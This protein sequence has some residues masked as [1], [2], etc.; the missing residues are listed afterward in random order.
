MKLSRSMLLAVLIPLAACDQLTGLVTDPDAPANLSYQLIPSGDPNAPL[1]VLLTWDVPS[2]GRGNAFNVYGRVNGADW[3]LRATTTSPTFHDAGIPETQYYVST[4]D[5]QGNELARSNTITIDMQARLPAP[6]GLRSISLNGAVQLQW[7]SNAVDASR[8]TFDH[9][10][11]YSATYDGTRGVCT[12]DWT[13]EGSTVSDAFLAANLTNGASRCFTVSAITHDGHES[14]WSDARVDTPRYDARN[15]IVYARPVKPDSAGFLFL[16]E[17]AKKIGVV[18][19][20]T[21]ADVDVTVERNAD[22]SL[23]LAPGRAGSTMTLY[24]TTAVPD[25]TSIDHAPASGFAS[26]AAIASPGFGYVFRLQK[27]DGVHFAAARVAYVAANYVVFD[28]S[29]QSAP[30]NAELNRAP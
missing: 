13:L 30:G 5:D 28:W 6:Q 1:G 2:S 21:R 12:A 17:S 29:Y 9:Y 23:S 24:S 25:L 7:S 11:V 8:A 15:V 3:Q 26:A 10:R 18:S 4:R 27:S 22:G 20:A 14:Q 19:A 16:D